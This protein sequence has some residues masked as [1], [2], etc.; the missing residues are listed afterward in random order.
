V[1]LT[2]DAYAEVERSGVKCEKLTVS[3]SGLEL[4]YYKVLPEP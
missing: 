3:V 2:A 1:L 4:T